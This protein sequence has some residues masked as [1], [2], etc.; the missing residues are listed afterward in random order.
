MVQQYEAA[1]RDPQ[2][3][4]ARVL[5]ALGVDPVDLGHIS[6]PSPTATPPE[7]RW[8]DE[9]LPGLR[10]ALRATY[11]PEVALLERDWGVD[12]SLWPSF[13]E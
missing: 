7:E 8:T 3:A 1:V 12:R 4:V 2:A 5:S 13:S 6:A 9:W 10:D 11:E